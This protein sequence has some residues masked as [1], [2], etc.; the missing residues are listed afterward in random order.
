MESGRSRGFNLY[1]SSIDIEMRAKT[2]LTASIGY[3]HLQI[4]L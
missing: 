2:L 4:A 3:N 1:T